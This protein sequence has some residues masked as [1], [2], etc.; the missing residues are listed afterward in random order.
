MQPEFEFFDECTMK[1]YGHVSAIGKRLPTP[2][3]V[4]EGGFFVHGHKYAYLIGRRTVRDKT[5][6][7]PVYK[8]VA[9]QQ[10]FLC[11]NLEAQAAVSA[12]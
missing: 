7:N 8:I 10:S 11:I 4:T 2:H 9:M 3:S 5:I 1:L 6:D 12:E